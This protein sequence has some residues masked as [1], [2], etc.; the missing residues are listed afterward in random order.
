MTSEITMFSTDSGYYFT[1]DT[2]TI[3][4]AT[5]YKGSSQYDYVEKRQV[6]TVKHDDFIQAL[7]HYEYDHDVLRADIETLIESKS[8][9]E[10]WEMYEYNSKLHFLHQ[11]KLILIGD[12]DWSNNDQLINIFNW[13]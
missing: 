12:H 4:I 9:L 1:V 8:S 2:D 13:Q 6:H 10:Y 5:V 11:V 7:Q 3:G